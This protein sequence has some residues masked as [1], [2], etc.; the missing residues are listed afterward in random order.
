MTDRGPFSALADDE[1]FRARAVLGP[2]ALFDA[3]LP[4]VLFTVVYAVGGRNLAVSLWVAI[5]AAV[6]IAVIRVL[7]RDPLQNVVAGL[8]GVGV[9]ALLAARTGRAEDVF[10]PG[11]LINAGYGL[12]FLV[13]ILVRWPL[14]GLFVGFA[15]GQGTSWRRDP[16]LMRAYSLASALFAAMFALRL[17]VQL[18]LWLAGEDHLGWLATARLVMS[19]P[20]FLLVAYLSWLIVRPAHRAAAMPST[21]GRGVR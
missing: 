18:P 21:G 12:A 20:L 10:A 7:R 19:W 8:L 1:R 5:G 11:L 15:T 6:V 16:A 13:S 2:M 17:A 3:G 9:A 14:L 4:L